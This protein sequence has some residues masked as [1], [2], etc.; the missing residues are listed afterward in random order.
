MKFAFVHSWRHRW[1]VELLCRVMLVSERGYRSCR[2]RPISCR[3]VG[4][5]VSDRMKK[6]LAIRALDMAVRLRQPPDGCIFHSDRGSQYCSYGYQKKLQAYG[7]RPSMSGKGNCYDNASVETFF[8]SLKA[9]LIW[10]QRWPMRR[11]A[12]AAIFQYINGFNNSRR[13]HSYL[14][15]ISPLAFEA[16]VA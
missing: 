11:Q 14:G 9:E 12:E 13:R 8:K 1:P 15:G 10:R 4:W 16:K 7:L 3:V 5:A 2:S 6:D